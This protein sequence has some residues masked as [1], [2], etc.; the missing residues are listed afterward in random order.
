MRDRG[1][2]ANGTIGRWL[3]EITRGALVESRHR[4]LAAVVTAAEGDAAPYPEAGPAV[5]PR[6]AAK[7]IQALPILAS[8]VAERYGLDEADVAVLAA[9]HGGT[10]RHVERVAGILARAG[11]S[12]ADLR[13][14][15]HPPLDPEAA[16]ELARRGER[17]TPLHNNCSGQHA[18][19][20]LFARHL[21]VDPAGYTD[22]DH[23]VQRAVSDA[24]ARLTDGAPL[25]VGIDGCGIPAPAVPLE[26]LARAF[27][28]L[29]GGRVDGPLA[30]PA[31]RLLA[32]MA[33]CPDLVAGPGRFD[34]VVMEALGGRAVV[35]GGAEGV[36]CA[37]LTATGTGIAV[38]AVD[39]TAR[40]A[41]VVMAMLLARHLSGLSAPAA[42]LLA[43]R[44]APV[45]RNASGMPVGEVRVTGPAAAD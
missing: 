37:A 16:A 24:L 44:A 9:S 20:V 42:A 18:G 19:F 8:G 31:A 13:C 14:G 25:D 34:T 10:P 12:A 27:A 38:K 4:V 30:G 40:A 23:P 5:F 26:K 39:G 41:E 3:V 32:A 15:I 28:R 6:S 7:P 17:P 45:V 1:T 36:L 43:A 29:A 11:A 35:K 2:V 33:A 22:L 21:G